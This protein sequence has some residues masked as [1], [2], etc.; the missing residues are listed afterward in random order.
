M[1]RIL[2]V[3]LLSL[4]LRRRVH[5]LCADVLGLH[6]LLQGEDGGDSGTAGT[7][8]SDGA[9][10]SPAAVRVSLEVGDESG[11]DPDGADDDDPLAARAPERAIPDTGASGEP[12]DA[13]HDGA[14]A[15]APEGAIHDAGAPGRA[16]RDAAGP[17]ALVAD[18]A[19][20]AKDAAAASDATGVTR[21]AEGAGRG[22]VPCTRTVWVRASRIVCRTA[23][24]TRRRR[25]RP[26]P[27]SPSI[28]RS[29]RSSRAPAADHGFPRQGPTK[30]LAARAPPFATA[31]RSWASTWD[32]FNPRSPPH[33]SRARRLAPSGTECAA[34]SYFRLF[35]RRTHGRD[36]API[37]S[38]Q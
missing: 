27:R 30:P 1:P 33:A 38:C 31:G 13:I 11:N 36:V 20:R 35:E 23:R 37:R 28:P 34:R 21:P 15:D 26:A 4:G 12:D 32:S 19:Q 17:D 3:H 7:L 14:D 22:A 5:F 24:T 25:G 29:A 8:S 16:I 9:A 6:D 2:R 18:A 10:D